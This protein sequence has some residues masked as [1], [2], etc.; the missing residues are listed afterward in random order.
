LFRFLLETVKLE[1]SLN[2]AQKGFTSSNLEIGNFFSS[3]SFSWW[4]F[5]SKKYICGHEK[6][7]SS[8]LFNYRPFRRSSEWSIEI[9]SS[10]VYICQPFDLGTWLISLTKI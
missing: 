4:N 8:S 5:I 3:F 10:T 7:L 1:L 6:L 9:S 2:S